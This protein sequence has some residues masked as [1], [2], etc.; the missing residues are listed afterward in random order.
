MKK[1][2]K[3]SQI[4][5]F[6]LIGIIIIVLMGFVFYINKQTSSYRTKKETLESH[7]TTFDITVIKDYIESCL[8]KTTR[9]GINLLGAQG[10][11][12]YENQGGIVISPLQLVQGVDY[13]IL[14]K[15]GTETNIS[16]GLKTI[17]VPSFSCE[18]STP[19]TLITCKNQET[20]THNLYPWENFPTALSGQ[21][22]T[23]AGCFG[24]N[25]LSPLTGTSSMYDQIKVYI[26]NKIEKCTD[27]SIFTPQGFNIS[28]NGTVKVEVKTND[29]TVVSTLIYPLSIT[30]PTSKKQTKIEEFYYDT[31]I[32]LKTLH[33]IAEE[34][35]ILDKN[36]GDFE[37]N[38][39]TH[40]GPITGL[41]N[42]IIID[43]LT[44]DP[45]NNLIFPIQ[46]NIVRITDNSNINRPFIFQFARQNR[47]PA[48]EEM[49]S[50]Q[51]RPIGDTITNADF[52]II[53]HDPDESTTTTTYFT[54]T[55]LGITK[56]TTINYQ[57]TAATPTPF[58]VEVC[59]SDNQDSAKQ[60]TTTDDSKDW[61]IIE[62]DIN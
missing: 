38:N 43:I 55:T 1:R 32:R 46:D 15:G 50:H 4:T 20:T 52:S 12:I 29:K 3:K 22:C 19:S 34:I 25:T 48:L 11:L 57:I 13:I 10:G 49:S 62:F 21:E 16:Y 59:V 42:N 17:N 41:Y 23:D 33:T 45:L 14:N 37:I 54:S 8:E 58:E 56:T 60:C 24:R 47:P 44:F 2:N 30:D 40:H 28:K 18:D 39:P 35:T 31:N 7:E 5:F 53:S 51:T 36:Y 26:E 6:I 61:Q 27:F 9:D